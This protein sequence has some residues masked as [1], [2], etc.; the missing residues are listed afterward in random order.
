[1]KFNHGTPQISA[2]AMTITTTIATTMGLRDRERVS[3][4]EST[5]PESIAAEPAPFP[6]GP[7]TVFC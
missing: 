4:P 1:M 2:I 3:S 6:F 7:A 5:E